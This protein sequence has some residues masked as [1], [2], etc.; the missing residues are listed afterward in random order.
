M[1]NKCVKSEGI[2]EKESINSFLATLLIII[3]INRLELGKVGSVGKLPFF[4]PATQPKKGGRIHAGENHIYPTKN[5]PI[6]MDRCMGSLEL[7]DSMRF[8]E[9]LNFFLFFFERE[10]NFRSKVRT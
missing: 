10:K 5:S 8:S 2:A 6:H 7:E 3:N 4:W 1:L 9:Y